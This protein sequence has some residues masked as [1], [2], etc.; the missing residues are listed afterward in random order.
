MFDSTLSRTFSVPPEGRT[1]WPRDGRGGGGAEGRGN[2]Y[3][4]SVPWDRNRIETQKEIWRWTF[5][6][7][8][9][10]SCAIDTPTRRNSP[11]R[12]LQGPAWRRAIGGES[13]P[14]CSRRGRSTVRPELWA[15]Q[16]TGGQMSRLVSSSAFLP[17]TL[18]GFENDDRYEVCFDSSESSI[19]Q[20][21]LFELEAEVGTLAQGGRVAILF[22]YYLS[23]LQRRLQ[24]REASIVVSR[25]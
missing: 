12:R 24:R 7:P 14:R 6:N 19:H 22:G 2:S 11:I 8:P 25:L 9:V 18:R 5:S 4:S 21:F 16:L 10:L 23:A 3:Y 20:L 1:S 13:Y 17:P 15:G